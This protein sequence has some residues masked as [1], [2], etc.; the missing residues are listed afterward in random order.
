MQQGLLLHEQLQELHRRLQLNTM[1][2]S[3]VAWRSQRQEVLALLVLLPLFLL[4][5][6]TLASSVF[7]ATVTHTI[8]ARSTSNTQSGLTRVVTGTA[9][10]ERRG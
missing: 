6:G 7:M 10:P 2:C 4:S 8:A 1:A 9:H 5:R 3:A